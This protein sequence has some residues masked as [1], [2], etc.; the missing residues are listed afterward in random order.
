MLV[1]RKTGSAGRP[2]GVF[3]RRDQEGEAPLTPGR[4]MPKDLGSQSDS[5]NDSDAN[6]TEE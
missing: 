1:L 5:G 2:A 3:A 6:G 4:E